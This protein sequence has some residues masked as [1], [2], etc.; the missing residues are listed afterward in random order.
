VISEYAVHDHLGWQR[1]ADGDW[2]VGI[3]VENGRIKDAVR[4]GLRA[5]VK[6]VSTEIRLTT[7]QNIVLTRIASVDRAR[8]DAMIAAYGLLI[9]CEPLSALRRYAM[10]CPALPTCGLAVAE[11][12]RYLPDVIGD[13]EQRGFGGERVWIRMSGCPNSC[14]RPPTAEIGIVGRSLG[15]YHVYVGGSFAGTRLARL[16]RADVRAAELVGVLADVL[17]QWRRERFAGEAFGDWADRTF[18]LEEAVVG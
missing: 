8:V 17:D 10:A 11:A 6:A 4:E 1:Q 16:Y 7:H 12:E 14:S 3:W 9:G 5:I 2:M 15:L 13:L 18:A